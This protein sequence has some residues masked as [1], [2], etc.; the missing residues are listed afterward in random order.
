MAMQ[1][2]YKRTKDT[3]GPGTM[4]VFASFLYFVGTIV[5]SFIPVETTR[6]RNVATTAEPSRSGMDGLE[7]P[8]LSQCDEAAP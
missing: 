8:L 7:E 6:E 2:I 1:L 3:I 5:V 4:F